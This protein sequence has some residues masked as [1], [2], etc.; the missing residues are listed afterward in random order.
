MPGWTLGTM[1]NGGLLNGQPFYT[2]PDGP[3]TT[4]YPHQQ[5]AEPWPDYPIAGQVIQEFNPWF[6]P[7]CGHSIKF[8]KIIK[9]WDDATQQSAAL[10][11]CSLCTFIQRAVEPYDE[12]L[13]PI[14]YAII[15]G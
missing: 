12:I 9:E 1:Y 6:T 10:I 8:W 2:Q 5:N 4:V 7:S 14:Q 15:V 13:N 11:C 3:Y